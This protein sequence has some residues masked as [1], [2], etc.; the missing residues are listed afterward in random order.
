MSLETVLGNFQQKAN[1]NQRVKSIIINWKPRFFI[2]AQDTHLCYQL[3][4]QDGQIATI[5]PADPDDNDDSILLVCGKQ[6]V[7]ESIFSGQLN[8]LSAYSSGQLEVYG[9]EADKV[10]LD[11]VSLIHWGF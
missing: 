6:Q 8:P 11:A 5:K 10:K 2:E 9:E 7:L 4:I 3:D 1:N